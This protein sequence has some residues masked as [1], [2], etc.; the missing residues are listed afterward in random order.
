MQHGRA[1]D[2]AGGQQFE[3]AP[4]FLPRLVERPRVDP[5]GRISSS[6]RGQTGGIDGGNHYHGKRGWA[7]GEVD[8]RPGKGFR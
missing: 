1:E 5:A 7:T 6:G 8:I 3:P 2:V 4:A